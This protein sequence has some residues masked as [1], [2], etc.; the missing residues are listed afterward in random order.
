M[1]RILLQV[2]LLIF[3]CTLSYAETEKEFFDK[4]VLLFKQGHYEGAVEQF[5]KL[6][7]IAPN[8]A[9]A[10]KN[11]GASYMKLEQFDTALAD[12]EKAK[13]LFPEL[14][15]LYSNL[16]VVC[17]YKKEY[18]KAIQYYDIELEMAPDNHIAHFNRAL[19]LVELRRD[20]EALDAIEKTLELK[21]NFYWALCYRGDLLTRSGDL[22]RAAES[23]EAALRQDPRNTYAKEK[24]AQ[25]RKDDKDKKDTQE[26][27]EQTTVASGTDKTLALQAG[28][29]LNQANAEKM[30]A[31]LIENGFDADI[32]VLKDKKDRTW[33][34]VRS[35]RY[36]SSSEAKKAALNLKEKLAIETAV[37]PSGEW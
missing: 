27:K 3:F 12:F 18:E 37:R 26:K 31:K 34:L 15:G 32:L 24:L 14:K 33:H 1:E 19:C 36:A 2:L 9:D 22:V 21:P 16:G 4:G 11:R 10:Y 7:E 28:A 6:I 30:K 17:Y 29:F 35:G 13:E 23:Y 5:S 20:G 8:N 25:I